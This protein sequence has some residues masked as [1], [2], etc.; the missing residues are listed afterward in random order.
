MLAVSDNGCGIDQ[1]HIDRIFERF[2]RVEPS[3]SRANGGS[4]L[5]LAIVRAIVNAHEGE[6]EVTSEL[7][8][9]TRFCISLPDRS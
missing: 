6:I 7:G 5:G 1:K 3:R 2:Y 4:G 8:K 9:G